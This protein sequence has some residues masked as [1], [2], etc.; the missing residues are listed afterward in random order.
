MMRLTMAGYRPVLPGRGP[1]RV[2]AYRPQRLYVAADAVV[3]SVIGDRHDLVRLAA[4]FRFAAGSRRT[5]IHVAARTNTLPAEL[6]DVGLGGPHRTGDLVLSHHS[7]AL[8]PGRWPDI[9]RRLGPGRPVTVSL[10]R[11]LRREPEVPRHP[12]TSRYAKPVELHREFRDHLRQTVHGDTMHLVGSHRAFESMVDLVLRL[13]ECGFEDSRRNGPPDFF[14]V[15]E[16]C[17]DFFLCF[18]DPRASRP[19]AETDAP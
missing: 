16:K 18:Y 15:R 3:P 6:A 4:L 2:L 14:W 9:R 5:V 13:S 12:S 1:L 8:R 19:P 17:L 11:P 10:R 7:L